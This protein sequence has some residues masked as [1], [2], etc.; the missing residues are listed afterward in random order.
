MKRDVLAVAAGGESNQASAEGPDSPLVPF[1][2]YSNY[3]SS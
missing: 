3:V 1:H 2:R